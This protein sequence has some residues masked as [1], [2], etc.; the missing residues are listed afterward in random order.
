MGWSKQPVLFA[1]KAFKALRRSD[2]DE[3]LTVDE[4]LMRLQLQLSLA[5]DRELSFD[6]VHFYQLHSTLTELYF[7]R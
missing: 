2:K 4:N 3:N 7:V 6:C 1:W 5:F